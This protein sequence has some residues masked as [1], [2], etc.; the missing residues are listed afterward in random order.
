MKTPARLLGPA[1]LATSALARIGA[2]ATM[3]F[4]FHMSYSGQSISGRLIGLAVDADGNAHEVTPTK[5][6]FF[7]VPANVG[8]TASPSNPYVMIPHMFSRSH[9]VGAFEYSTQPNV[10]GFNI[11]NRSMS[12]IYQN[13]EMVDASSVVYLYFNWGETYQYQGGTATTG[14]SA[15][16]EYDAYWPSVNTGLSFTAVSPPA[17]PSDVNAD[18]VVNTA[19]LSA[20][21]A[22]FGHAVAPFTQGDADGDA[23]V[24]TA[25][26]SAMLGRFGS[27]CP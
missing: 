27:A 22:H 26:L 15:D 6:L 23:F 12:G 7:S 13:L 17:C 3:D 16:G 10:L 25:D 20:L 19:D 11:T 18:H 5:V 4:D 14:M 9:P 2:A 24:N 1:V 21:L 8:I